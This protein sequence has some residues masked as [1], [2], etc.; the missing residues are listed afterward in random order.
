MGPAGHRQPPLQD[1][2]DGGRLGVSSTRDSGEH[3]GG[4]DDA[5]GRRRS[6]LVY[7]AASDILYGLVDRQR[8]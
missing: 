3:D 7:S 8:E 6:P 5:D 2:G 1:I 4:E